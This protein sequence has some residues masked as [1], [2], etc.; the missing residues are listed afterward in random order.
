MNDTVPLFRWG[1][2]IAASLI[3][4]GYDLRARRIPNILTFPLALTGM[5]FATWHNGIA[6]L[7]DAMGA[8]VLLALPYIILFIFAGGGAG[9][10]KLMAAIGFWLGF[11]Q[12]IVVLLAVSLAAVVLGLA[13]A[14]LKKC[15]RATL[16]G[17]FVKIYTFVIFLFSGRLKELLK[18][19]PAAAE[20]SHSGQL[21]MPYGVAILI[22]VCA[23][24]IYCLLFWGGKK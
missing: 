17:I 14:L 13:T 16:T 21:T 1:I 2:V 15:L 19:R 10:A 11:E 22:G 20:F 7:A 9:D 6:G 23:A 3:A 8:G 12:G 18:P 4:A 24:A 5:L